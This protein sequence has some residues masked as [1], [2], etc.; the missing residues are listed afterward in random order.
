MS[1]IDH[2]SSL[3]A[4]Q[5]YGMATAWSEL[6][7]EKPRQTHRP[8]TWMER[9]LV[10]EKMDRQ[11]KSLRY[12]LKAARFPIHRDLLGI[13]WGD[14]P[15][16]QSAVEQLATATFMETAHNLI[17]GVEQALGNRTWKRQL[18]SP[19][20]IRASVCASIM[21]SIWSTSWSV[22]SHLANS[23]IWL[24]SSA[25]LMPSFLTS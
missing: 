5:L 17:L 21:R 14:T 9:L 24:S 2:I 19:L 12:Q 4:L 10:A 8:E 20:F 23:E 3:K 16:S 15:L 6:Q 11:L 13:D 1:S 25:W 7:A 22:R 18:A